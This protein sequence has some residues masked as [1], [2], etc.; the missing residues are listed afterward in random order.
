MFVRPTTYAYGNLTYG[1]FGSTYFV[2]VVQNAA[3]YYDLVEL[4]NLTVE[5]IPAIHVGSDWNAFP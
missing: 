1:F 3:T 2:N 5:F 4:K